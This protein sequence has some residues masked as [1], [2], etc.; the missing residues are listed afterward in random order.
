MHRLL[1]YLA[2]LAL[3][4]AANAQ[5][6]VKPITSAAVWQPGSDFVAKAH[7]AC[8]KVSPSEKFAECV[9]SQMSGAGASADAVTFTRG[10]YKQQGEFGIMS[11]FQKVGPVDIAWVFYPLR[12]SYGLLL[13]NRQA[14]N[15]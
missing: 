12:P 9:I 15:D 11:G 8:D 2:T 14:A 5:S 7:A 3:A 1:L 13:V 6:D 10:L 4:L